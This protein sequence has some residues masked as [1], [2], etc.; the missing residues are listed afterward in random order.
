MLYNVQEVNQLSNFAAPMDFYYPTKN[1]GFFARSYQWNSGITTCQDQYWKTIQEY[2][3]CVNKS[4]QYSSPCL[5]ERQAILDEWETIS[6]CRDK[7]E[8]QYGKDLDICYSIFLQCQENSSYGFCKTG[9]ETCKSGKKF[10]FIEKYDTCGY[11]YFP[12]LEDYR[13]C[14][15]GQDYK[16]YIDFTECQG[17]YS[18]QNPWG[19]DTGDCP[20]TGDWTKNVRDIRSGCIQTSDNKATKSEEESVQTYDGCIEYANSLPD[21]DDRVRETFKCNKELTERTDQINIVFSGDNKI[22]QLAYQDQYFTDFIK[23]N[24]NHSN[25]LNT[26]GKV[27][28]Q[29][30]DN[31]SA[32][33]WQDTYFPNQKLSTDQKSYLGL[34]EDYWGCRGAFMDSVFNCNSVYIKKYGDISRTY[35]MGYINCEGETGCIAQN[36]SKRNSDYSELSNETNNCMKAPP[37]D[38][39]TC[40]YAKIAYGLQ[41]HGYY[42]SSF[43]DPLSKPNR[44]SYY[45]SQYVD[46]GDPIFLNDPYMEVLSETPFRAIGFTNSSATFTFRDSTQ[47]ISVNLNPE[48]PE[49][50][51]PSDMYFL[52]TFNPNKHQNDDLSK[53]LTNAIGDFYKSKGTCESSYERDMGNVYLGTE[54]DPKKITQAL[55]LARNNYLDCKS[56]S[57][58]DF[59][60]KKKEAYVN[61]VPDSQ[62]KFITCFFEALITSSPYFYEAI[63]NREKAFLT[64]APDKDK[65]NYLQKVLKFQE[66]FLSKVGDCC[67]GFIYQTP[68]TKR[69][70]HDCTLRYFQY[71]QGLPGLEGIN[72]HSEYLT[73]CFDDQVGFLDK[74]NESS[75][76]KKG[77]SGGAF[78]FLNILSVNQS[79]NSTENNSKVLTSTI[80]KGQISGPSIGLGDLFRSALILSD[81]YSLTMIDIDL[82]NRVFEDNIEN[83]YLT[84]SIFG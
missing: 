39:A 43:K 75:F 33:C 1:G 68:E 29:G 54:R 53:S 20:T 69:R 14:Q 17:K 60:K 57:D 35:E 62:K 58:V 46:P 40:A 81:D 65:K 83:V 51:Q 41:N 23:E 6:G 66:I 37:I 79:F 77:L 61:F 44:L 32:K 34:V 3:D 48:F 28:Y 2:E 24:Y 11:T 67:D 70:W 72:D 25:C 31:T 36:L 74:W 76:T 4:F 78:K 12:V 49:F 42:I 59:F 80:P 56:V 71:L 10:V 84:K 5:K 22:C 64:N 63:K 18:A 9:L 26:K 73:K 21:F 13:F 47:N 52:N 19:N 16:I 27:Y 30:Y 38:Y 7:V 15:T 82:A 55:D 50:L 8:I 45:S